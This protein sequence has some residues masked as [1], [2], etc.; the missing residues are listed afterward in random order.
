ACVLALVGLMLFGF[1]RGAAPPAL[2]AAYG[3]LGMT[4]LLHTF[5]LVTRMYIQGRPPVTNLYSSAIFIGWGCVL[6]G[7]I[8][9]R[10]YPMGVASLAG[11]TLGFVTTLIAHGL[12]SDRDTMEMMQ[13]VLDTNLWLATH[14]TLVTFGYVA[15]YVAGF[16]G[17]LFILLGVFTPILD[18]STFKALAGII[19][20]V[21]CFAT[22][23][24]FVGT[25]LGGIWADYSWGRFW[26]W[27]PKENGA[28]LIVLWNAVVL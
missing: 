14:V 16:L 27:D 19:Y 7:L 23:L 11:A 9:E 10:I 18:R 22:F 15:T 25:V 12:G 6:M 3:L 4:F 8:L 1:S 24:S 20:G 17:I 13:A 26:G 2:W 5:G 21:V 28:F